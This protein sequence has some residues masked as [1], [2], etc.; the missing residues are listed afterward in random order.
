[1]YDRTPPELIVERAASADIIL[2]NKAL[3]AAPTL[4]RLDR[5]KFV[6]VTATGYN[7]VDT[8]A[9]AARGVLVSNVPEYST[10]TVAQH[11]IAMLLEL[12]NHVGRHDASVHRGEWTRSP[13]WCYTV[14]PL[15]ELRGKRL[16]VVGFGKIG[17]RVGQ[18]AA[19][20][21]MEILAVS[22]RGARGDVP[23]PVTRLPLDELFAQSHVVSLHCP[24]TDETKGLINRRRLQTMKREALLINCARG[25]VVVERDLADALNDGTIA[26]AAADVVSDEP[27]RAENPLLAARNCIITPHIG[28]ATNEAKSRLIHATA[29]NIAAFLDGRPINVVN[30]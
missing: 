30:R 12:C 6:A 8:A 27:I 24:L 29:A 7:V 3:L 16:G 20:L 25:G 15:V 28:W 5:L 9:A 21:G 11:A 13:D 26:G 22:G 10:D 17:Q 4:G 14:A 1:V 19:A 23:Y 2:T 18:I